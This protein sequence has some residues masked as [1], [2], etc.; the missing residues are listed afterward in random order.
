MPIGIVRDEHRVRFRNFREAED[1]CQK[2]LRYFRYTP[3]CHCGSKHEEWFEVKEHIAL[4]VVD[5]WRR[6][7]R[8]MPYDRK[9]QISSWW[10]EKA[11]PG[12]FTEYPYGDAEESFSDHEE[13]GRRWERWLRPP[14]RL[15]KAYFACWAF[16]F[17]ERQTRRET[18]WET[19]SH[20]SGLIAIYFPAVAYSFGCWGLITHAVLVCILLW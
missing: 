14:S 2:E 18:R 8:S 10:I 15:Q 20:K 9:G 17:M 7:F 4:K 5:R 3:D 11:K 6:W 1:L 19:M 13:R 12:K 16:L